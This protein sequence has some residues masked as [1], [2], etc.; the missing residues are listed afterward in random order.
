MDQEPK[1]PEIL[2]ATPRKGS[3]VAFLG[4]LLEVQ[5]SGFEVKASKPELHIH[6]GFRGEALKPKP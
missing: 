1:E 5:G 2:Q 6:G 3:P 4:R